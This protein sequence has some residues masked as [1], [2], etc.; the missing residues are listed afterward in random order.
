MGNQVTKNREL[1]TYEALHTQKE[2]NNRP[3]SSHL[4]YDKS[5]QRV[6]KTLAKRQNVHWVKFEL[7][8]TYQLFTYL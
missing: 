6:Q 1:K 5:L 3:V 4:H 7:T 8:Y 2:N